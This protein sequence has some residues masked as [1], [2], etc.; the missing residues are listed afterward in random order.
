MWWLVWW[1]LFER[2]R[3]GARKI[4]H[5]YINSSLISQFIANTNA[6]MHTTRFHDYY[7]YGHHGH[8]RTTDILWYVRMEIIWYV[9]AA[10]I[11]YVRATIIW[12]VCAAITWYVC[13]VTGHISVTQFVT[14]IS[15]H[16]SFLNSPQIQTPS[17]TL[18]AFMTIMLMDTTDTNAQRI[19]YGTYDGMVCTYASRTHHCDTI[20]HPYINSSL[21]SQFTANTNAIM[22]TTRFHDY[23][24]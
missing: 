14:H 12:Y 7:A 19:Y 21:I 20:R 4:R 8:Q 17:C 6:I 5:S 24:A 10:I 2:V 13:A 11:W 1:H 16:H 3:Q 22:H 9:C 23:Y 15:I 18:H